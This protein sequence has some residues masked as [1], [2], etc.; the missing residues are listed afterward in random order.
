LLWE[1]PAGLLDVPGE[2]ADLTAGRELFE[3][4][5]YRAGR[6]DVLVDIY[7]TPGMCD[8]ALRLFLARDL[9]AVADSERY[10]GEHEEADMPLSWVPLDDAVALVLDGRLHNPTAV[11]GILAV[12]AARSR[13]FAGL[14]P[15]DAPWPE[16]P[17]HSA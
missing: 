17:E 4:A 16:R 8:E 11:A 6:W 13:G 14:R 15:V 1:P 12:A 9:T 3:E 7:T 2:R 10:A 5:G